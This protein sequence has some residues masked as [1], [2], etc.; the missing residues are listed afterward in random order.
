M[1]LPLP[2]PVGLLRRP[3]P[4][5]GRYAHRASHQRLVKILAKN[6]LTKRGEL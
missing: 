3:V 1:P 2:R 6:L 5:K 4:R